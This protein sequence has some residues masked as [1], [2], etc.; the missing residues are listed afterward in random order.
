MKIGYI[1]FGENLCRIGVGEVAFLQE[2]GW[3]LGTPRVA[4]ELAVRALH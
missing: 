4:K 1:G 3:A 2:L